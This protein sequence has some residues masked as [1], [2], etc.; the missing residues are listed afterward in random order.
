LALLPGL[1]LNDASG[2]PSVA[3][4]AILRG[5]DALRWQLD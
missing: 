4:E 5:G 1:T 2:Q 3:A